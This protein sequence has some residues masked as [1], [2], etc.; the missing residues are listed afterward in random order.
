MLLDCVVERTEQNLLKDRLAKSWI[1]RYALSE[2]QFMLAQIR[3]K[4]GSLPG[5][6]GGV[7]LNASE[8]ISLAE[9]NRA[10]LME[11]IDDFIVNDIEGQGLHSTFI[12]G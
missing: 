6:G 4:F 10:E 11:Q 5:A 1:E 3:G 2:C 12:I 8:L 9:N 7:S